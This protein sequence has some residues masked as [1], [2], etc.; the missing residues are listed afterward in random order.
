MAITCKKAFKCMLLTSITSALGFS[1][2]YFTF[3]IM[4]IKSMTAFGAILIVINFLLVCLFFP[5]LLI[6][7]EGLALTVLWKRPM[8]KVQHGCFHG[9]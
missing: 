6:T 4:P 9:K 5:A 2:A 7:P 8:T 1:I 3:E